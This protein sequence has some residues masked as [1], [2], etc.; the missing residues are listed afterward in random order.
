MRSVNSFWRSSLVLLVSAA[1]LV[2]L[3]AP[4][5]AEVST[6]AAPA[7]KASAAASAARSQLGAKYVF[8]GES[9]Q[10]G[11]DSS[12]LAQWAYGQ[13]GVSLPRTVAQQVGA[14]TAVSRA[15]LL[16]GDLVF[17]DFD[18]NG[19][20]DRVGVYTGSSHFVISVDP[21]GVVDRTLGWSFYN[22]HYVTARRIVDASGSPAPTPAPSTTLGDRIVAHARTFMGIPY[23]F[24]TH[25]PDTYDC[26]GYT[27]KVFRD[28]GISIPRT[29]LQQSGVGTFISKSN[30]KPGDLVFFKDT[31]K[32]GVSHVGIYVGGNKMIN[33][34]PGAGVTISDMTRPYFASRYWGAR[35]VW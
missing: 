9:L 16:P 23:K 30:L 20:A 31:Y 29:S 7:D 11:F 13:Q 18:K 8:G 5:R 24:G 4:A 14:G 1:T 22:T 25:G 27:Q 3:Q 19:S 6:L 2:T 26:S 21:G 33:A 10:T 28:M 32:P 12:G 17:F 15:N 34:W 35:R